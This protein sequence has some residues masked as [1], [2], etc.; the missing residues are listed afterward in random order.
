MLLRGE[1]QLSGWL[2][3]LADKAYGTDG[4]GGTDKTHKTDAEDGTDTD[5]I[6]RTT[7]RKKYIIGLPIPPFPLG[8][9]RVYCVSK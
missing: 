5:R 9:R 3:S 7:G 4:T 6:D 8:G 2:S 1:G